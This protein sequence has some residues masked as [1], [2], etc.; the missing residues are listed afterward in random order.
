[1]KWIRKRHWLGT[2]YTLKK[3]LVLEDKKKTMKASEN[4]RWK[5]FEELSVVVGP[6]IQ[7][8]LTCLRMQHQPE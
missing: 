3:D 7:E 2:C 8:E 1:M 5:C 6:R 4:V